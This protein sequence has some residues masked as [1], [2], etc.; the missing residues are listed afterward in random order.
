MA[1]PWSARQQRHLSAISEFTTTILHVSGKSNTVADALSRT[2]INS[3]H[4]LLPGVYYTEMA[5]A[6]ATDPEMSTYRTAISGLVLEDIP[7]G[8]SG[9]TLLC[10]VSTGQPR[11]VVPTEWRRHVFDTVHGLS[12]ASVRLPRTLSPAN[13]SG[14]VYANK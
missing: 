5:R 9:E 12:H 2:R 7:F 4:A 14:M 10:D 6:Q 13:L 1:D 11:P 8:T 3:L